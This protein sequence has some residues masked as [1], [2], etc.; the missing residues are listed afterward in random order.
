M[1][2]SL[3]VLGESLCPAGED[4]VSW[5]RRGGNLCPGGISVSWGG[6]TLCSGD[7]LSEVLSCMVVLL[8]MLTP[9]WKLKLLLGLW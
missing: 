4:S 8:W 1:S 5:W 6:R 9:R 7:S 2:W 3:C